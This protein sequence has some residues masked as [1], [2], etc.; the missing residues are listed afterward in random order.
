MKPLITLILAAMVLGA[1]NEAVEVNGPD[2]PVLADTTLDDLRSVGRP[3]VLNIWASWCVP[4][5][6]EAPL[7]R[8]AHAAFRDQV[9][10]VGIDIEDTQEAAKRFIAEFD[11]EFDNYFDQAGRIRSRLGGV[12]VPI[13]YFFDAGGD[14]VYQH[15]GVIDERTLAIQ[16][17]EILNR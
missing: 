7:L 4:C 2:L 15:N 9:H 6:S 17:D 1:C 8:E 13:T 11:L 16:I 10:F 12:G 3:L 14:I 5:R